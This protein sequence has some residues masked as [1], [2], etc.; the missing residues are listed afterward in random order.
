[1]HA[2]PLSNLVEAGENHDRFSI[3]PDLLSVL[4]QAAATHYSTAGPFLQAPGDKGRRKLFL[5]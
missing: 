1:M 5:P 2:G 4:Q 3:R